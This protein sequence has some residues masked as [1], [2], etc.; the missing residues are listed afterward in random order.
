LSREVQQGLLDCEANRFGR[1]PVNHQLKFRR[2]LLCLIRQANGRSISQP[3]GVQA[4]RSWV[5]C[6]HW[7]SHTRM[8]PR[9]AGI[10]SASRWCRSGRRRGRSSQV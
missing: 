10:S 8:P 2:V 1:S 4:E 5:V 7:R 3:A 9:P 6:G